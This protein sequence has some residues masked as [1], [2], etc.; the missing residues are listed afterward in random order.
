MF[1]VTPYDKWDS[2]SPEVSDDVHQHADSPHV[3]ALQAPRAA[4]W[5]LNHNHFDEIACR[6]ALP[7]AYDHANRTITA[8][9]CDW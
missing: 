2:R 4:R 3:F 8:G 6:F 9:I 7:K 5:P 1:T